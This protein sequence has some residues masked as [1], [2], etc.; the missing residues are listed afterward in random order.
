MAV[1]GSCLHRI[2]ASMHIIAQGFGL[3]KY[4]PVFHPFGV[5]LRSK[6]APYRFVTGDFLKE[7]NNSVYCRVQKILC[8]FKELARAY[9]S[10]EKCG[11]S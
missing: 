3:M 6:S 7:W 1:P 10:C 5:A 2:R 9:H 4:F 11:L 8:R